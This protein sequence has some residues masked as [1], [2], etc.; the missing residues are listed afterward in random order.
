MRIYLSGPMTGLPENNYPA[1][2]TAAEV[3]R[4]RGYTVVNP[5]ENIMPENSSWEDFMRLDIKQMLDCDA[6]AV[7]DDWHDSKGSRMEVQIAK[8]LG[9]TVKV[10]GAWPVWESRPPRIDR[11]KEKVARRMTDAAG[12][13]QSKY[14][15][16]AEVPSVRG[17]YTD[18]RQN[19][20]IFAEECAEVIQIKSKII[21]FGID[22]FHPKNELPNRQALEREIGHLQF[23]IS[24]LVDNGTISEA[25]LVEGRD[26]K[27]AKM[28]KWYR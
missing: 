28:P 21:R 20:E 19:L 27:A 14:E 2:N 4:G 10:L 6:L 23:M 1:F 16:V 24:V 9:M 26:H 25:G 17:L 7:L 12:I 11:A 5:A 8:T 3:L 15:T 22:D 13:T 18:M